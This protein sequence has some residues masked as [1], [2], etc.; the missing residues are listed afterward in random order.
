M[1]HRRIPAP[2]SSSPALPA[3][4]KRACPPRDNFSGRPPPQHFPVL[5]PLAGGP[6]FL[7][8]RILPGRSRDLPGFFCI[9]FLLCPH[10]RAGLSARCADIGKALPRAAAVSA[11]CRCSRLARRT[12]PSF[13]PSLRRGV[14][15]LYPGRGA[16]AAHRR[17]FRCAFLPVRCAPAL[18]RSLPFPGRRIFS[19]LFAPSPIRPLQKLIISLNYHHKVTNRLNYTILVCCTVTCVDQTH[20]FFFFYIHV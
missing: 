1:A 3:A 12:A 6:F 2:G 17:L 19:Q 5:A 13:S 15:P 14:F 8:Y 4:E 18:H 10:P 11:F 20:P 16:P 7:K 9:S